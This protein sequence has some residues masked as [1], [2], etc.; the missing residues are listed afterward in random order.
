MIDVENLSFT[1]PGTTSPVL[2]NLSFE[3][4][5]GEVYGLLGPSGAGKSTTQKI[6]MGLQQ[7][8]SGKAEIFGQPVHTMGR[9]L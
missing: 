4:A 7:G 2:D 8:F 5:N 1:Y 3:I 6:L 9:A